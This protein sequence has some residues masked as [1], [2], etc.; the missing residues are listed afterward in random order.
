MA[1][2]NEAFA[3]VRALIGIGRELV[4]APDYPMVLADFL[5]ELELAKDAVEAKPHLHRADLASNL[6]LS[7]YI[8]EALD[9]AEAAGIQ[10]IPLDGYWQSSLE[11]RA[12][13]LEETRSSS[14]LENLRHEPEP[15]ETAGWAQ[16]TRDSRHP[17][18][19]KVAPTEEQERIL[20]ATKRAVGAG[21]V[22]AE[23]FAGT[24]KTTLC[25]FIVEE[26]ESSSTIY[27]AFNKGMAEQAKRRLKG[28]IED[29][30]TTDSLACKIIKPWEKWGEERTKPGQ[31]VPWSYVAERLGLPKGFGAYK[32]GIL[33]RQVY[34]AVMNYCYSA[35]SEIATHHVP[36]LD[37]PSGGEEQIVQWAKELWSLMLLNS[38]GLPVPPAQV[39]KYW[40]L[41]EGEI[42]YKVVLFDE[43]QDANGAFMSVLRRS[44]CRRILIGDHHQQ[45]YDWR[46]AVNAMAQI[47][48]SAFP[49]TQ[50]WRF[51]T[52]IA[53]FA[54]SILRRKSEPPLEQILGNENVTS[55]ISL[56]SRSGSLPEW[57]VTVLA[58]T[59]IC[60]FNEAVSIAENGHDFHIV[61][62]IADLNW[63]MLDALRLFNDEMEGIVPHPTLLRF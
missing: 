28:A 54:N 61:G 7:R 8:G 4:N 34:Q 60:V 10:F 29:C 19:A 42:P 48:G 38:E 13:G 58:R 41:K 14:P 23:A 40:D 27:L 37:W 33:V 44:G 16:S 47:D 1:L 31:T 46:G 11:E 24:G 21:V 35:D 3:A 50:S 51:G 55:S 52:E 22:K 12:H 53:E 25:G 49:L 36:N 59:N 20:E 5:S 2:P 63:L 56:Y 15:P 57:P 32:R 26:L 18:R 17:F 30:R 43:A 6:E 39:M 45:L 9:A 62:G